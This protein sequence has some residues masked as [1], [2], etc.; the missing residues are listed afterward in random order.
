MLG[1]GFSWGC[2]GSGEKEGQTFFTSV[3]GHFLRSL[4]FSALNLTFYTTSWALTGAMTLLM[5]LSVR[6]DTVLTN[7]I[8]VGTCENTG[9]SMPQSCPMGKLC[10]SNS[11]AGI[12]SRLRFSIAGPGLGLVPW[13]RPASAGRCR[14]AGFAKVW[15]SAVLV[16]LQMHHELIDY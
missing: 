12:I 1:S 5:D 13:C 7:K 2:R 9:K 8:W 11:Q 16:L 10:V 4:A 6:A 14:T 3:K 15:I